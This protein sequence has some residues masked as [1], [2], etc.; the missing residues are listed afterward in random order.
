MRKIEIEEEEGKRVEF[1]H[2]GLVKSAGRTLRIRNS[3]LTTVRFPSFLQRSSIGSFAP[4]LL[5]ASRLSI[6]D[7]RWWQS[8]GA[9][10]SMMPLR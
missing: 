9:N 10:E 1:R 8:A 3:V 7:V 6:S 5:R 2:S 4:Y